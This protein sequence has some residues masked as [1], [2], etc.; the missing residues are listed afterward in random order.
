[1]TG[2]HLPWQDRLWAKVDRSDPEA[3]WPF[4]GSRNEFGYGGLRV[5][6]KA[7]KAHRLAWLTAHP[8]EVLKPTDHICHTCDNPPCCNPAHL[9]KGDYRTNTADKVAR[10]R[11]LTGER[12]SQALKGHVVSGD[13]HWTRREPER[14][15]LAGLRGSPPWN[16][17][18]R[19]PHGTRTRYHQGCRCGDCRAANTADA[20]K[21]RKAKAS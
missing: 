20:R 21:F 11:H 19:S 16:R 5:D 14:M 15:N 7:T 8:G 2:R 4:M 6:G 13:Q 1:M 18:R 3:C 10:A 12:L 17:G 9:Y